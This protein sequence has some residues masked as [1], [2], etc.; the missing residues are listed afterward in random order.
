MYLVKTFLVN[1]SIF[2]T[3]DYFFG[4][5]KDSFCPGEGVPRK[6]V[7]EGR[8]GTK[9]KF[10]FFFTAR[11]VVRWPDLT[12]ARVPHVRSCEAS[13]GLSGSPARHLSVVALQTSVGTRTD[14]DHP[15]QPTSVWR[16]READTTKGIRYGRN[17]RNKIHTLKFVNHL[18]WSLVVFPTLH[19]SQPLVHRWHTHTYTMTHTQ[20]HIVWRCQQ[21]RTI[22]VLYA[23]P[24]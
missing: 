20:K 1:H 4:R 7:K 12:T 19:L 16:H 17:L 14:W 11:V 6:G 8:K 22:T 18:S 23:C 3:L 24:V 10:Q 13:L 21:V 15:Y 2:S 9:K 5:K